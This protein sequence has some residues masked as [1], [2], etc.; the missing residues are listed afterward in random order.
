MKDEWRIV[1][2]LRQCP[3]MFRELQENAFDSALLARFLDP[4]GDE[5]PEFVAASAHLGLDALK[6][7]RVVPDVERAHRRIFDHPLAV[8]AH[9]R[10]R[11]PCGL[12]LVQAQ[13]LRGDDD[14][15]GQTLEVPLPRRR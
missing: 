12:V 13:I 11:R 10:R 1:L 4:P 3:V 5:F 9:R 14:A 6:G 7:D 2:D 15:R 8:G